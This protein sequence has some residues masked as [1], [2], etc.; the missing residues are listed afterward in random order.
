MLKALAAAIASGALLTSVSGTAAAAPP[1]TPN[2][3]LANFDKGVA[4]P[5]FALQITGTGS[6]A[7]IIKFKNGSMITA[8]RGYLLTFTN[9]DTGKSITIKAAG[10]VQKESTDPVTGITTGQGSGD[11]GFVYFPTDSPPG[12]STIMYT[13]L[14]NYTY[15]SAG[16]YTVSSTKGTQQDICAALSS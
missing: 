7:R 13:G 12:P 8:G 6:K 4:C 15:D 9:V 10:S 14:I 11:N 5:D 3:L 2:D 1:P 16:N